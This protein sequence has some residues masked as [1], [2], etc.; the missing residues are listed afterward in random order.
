ML[1]RM[2]AVWQASIKK[3]REKGR[4]GIKGENTSV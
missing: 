4:H 3:P 2:S 1:Q